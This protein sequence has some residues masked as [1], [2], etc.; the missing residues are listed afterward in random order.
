MKEFTSGDI[1]NLCSRSW[2]IRKTMLCEA[3]LAC[4]GKINRI[5]SIESK[6]TV[7]DYHHDEHERQISIHSSP[8][9]GMDE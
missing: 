6:N 9:S 1:R 3:M 4:A 2:S 5:G 7:S 8:S